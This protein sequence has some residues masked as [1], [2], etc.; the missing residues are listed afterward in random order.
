M[1][2]AILACLKSALASSEALTTPLPSR[3]GLDPAVKAAVRPYVETWVN[4]RLRDAVAAI[5]GDAEAMGHIKAA[6]ARRFYR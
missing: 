5:E 1:N 3:C 4:Q 6:D 2:N